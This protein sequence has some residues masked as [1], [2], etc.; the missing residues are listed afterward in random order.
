MGSRRAIRGIVAWISAS[1]LLL[2]QY[3][4]AASE[5]D[6][7]G[8]ATVIDGDTIE[9]RGERVRLNGI[10]APEASQYCLDE[11][12]KKYRCGSES[13][14][15]LSRLLETSTPVKCVF[16]DRDRYGRFVGECRLANGRSVQEWLVS[17]GFALDW[18]KYSDGRYN[19]FQEQARKHR[20]G[21]W[22]GEFLA[23]WEWRAQNRPQT[24]VEQPIPQVSTE[25]T[26][27]CLVKGNINSKGIRIFHMP[28]QSDY[29]KTRI[30]QD[31]G[32]RWFCSAEEALAAG[33]RPAAQ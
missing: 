22:R 8:R 1:M 27:P 25:P 14:N 31:K 10:D 7:V 19:L 9:V 33:W 3:A 11:A 5:S 17:S 28:G 20:R 21:M 15:A 32:E 6:L 2:G 29:Q 23:P 18:P 24:I 12:S 4:P 26:S 30:S 13:A 16:F